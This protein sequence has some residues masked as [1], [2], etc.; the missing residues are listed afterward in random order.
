MMVHRTDTLRCGLVV[1]KTAEK[2]FKVDDT[3]ILVTYTIPYM[4]V[5]TPANYH[6]LKE[7]YQ[8]MLKETNNMGLNGDKIEQVTEETTDGWDR[9]IFRVVNGG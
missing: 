8:Y 2:Y 4:G 7:F 3:F 1:D 5:W 9:I 6:T